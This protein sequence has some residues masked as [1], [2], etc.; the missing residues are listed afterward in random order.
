MISLQPWKYFRHYLQENSSGTK[1]RKRCLDCESQTEMAISTLEW[2]HPYWHPLVLSHSICRHLRILFLEIN[3]PLMH[4]NER[5]EVS[6]AAWRF[7]SRSQI[8][9]AR[10]RKADHNYPCLPLS[11]NVLFFGVCSFITD[12]L[13]TTMTQTRFPIV[14]CFSTFLKSDRWSS[15]FVS[16]IRQVFHGSLQILTL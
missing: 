12:Y 2:E 10:Y 9:K 15:I 16:K 4:C 14:S 1:H 13:I 6:K 7:C 5:P 3:L 11:V 8:L